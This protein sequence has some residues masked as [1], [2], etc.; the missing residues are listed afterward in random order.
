MPHKAVLSLGS[1]LDDRLAYLQSALDSLAGV[2]G[3][4]TVEVSPV[5]E[6]AH[7]GGPPQPDYLNVVALLKTV[8]TAESLLE[9]AHAIESALHR[10][11]TVRWGPRTIDVDLIAYDDTTS[12]DPS[13]TLPHPRAHQRLFVLQPWHDVDPDAALP[14][15]GRI[16]DLLMGL[17]DQ[18]V[19][20]RRELRLI[21]T[22]PGT[23]GQEKIR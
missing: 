1:N 20:R 14:G 12:D 5:Y 22:K 3:V 15:R 16:A 6:T 10:T 2:P 11:R 7:V 21:T 18:V 4:E 9:A 17:Q 8:L 19:I 23:T 13:L